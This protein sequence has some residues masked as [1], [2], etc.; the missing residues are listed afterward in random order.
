VLVVA[1]RGGDPLGVGSIED[2]RRETSA[3]DDLGRQQVDRSV[4]PGAHADV[5]DD[6][7]QFRRRE[8][9]V[10]GRVGVLVRVGAEHARDARGVDQQVRVD[11]LGDCRA[12]RV[13]RLCGRDPTHHRDV[14][15]VECRARVLVGLGGRRCGLVAKRRNEQPGVQS[16]DADSELVELDLVCPQ[17]ARCRDV[18][19]GDDPAPDDH[20]EAMPLGRER[21]DHVGVGPHP[22][23]FEVRREDAPADRDD[24][25]HCRRVTP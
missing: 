25:F 16:R 2:D 24:D 19:A 17:F 18:I 3:F 9:I 15:A 23:R 13:G 14:A 7:D 21:F 12:D 4:A 11:V 8:R 5:R 1:D 22:L 6:V 20:A 10:P